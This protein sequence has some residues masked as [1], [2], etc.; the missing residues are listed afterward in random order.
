MSEVS[1]TP[2]NSGSFQGY[3]LYTAQQVAQWPCVSW[4]VD[5]IIQKNSSAV[6]Y[7]ESRAGKSFLAL[8]LAYKLAAGDTWFGYKVQPC[9]VIFFAAES[10]SGLPGRISAI[11]AHQ[12]EEAPE[13]LLFMREHIELSDSVRI[14][15]LI[16]TVNGF[17]VIF[18]DTLNAAAS[19]TNEN[20]VKEMGKILNGIRR[21]IDETGCTVI[22]V[23]HC[24]W[25]DHERLRGHSSFSAAMDTRIHVTRE[26]GHPTWKV[27]GQREGAETEA[28]RYALRQIILPSGTSCIVDPLNTLPAAKLAAQPRTVN[29]KIVYQNALS[30]LSK[31]KSLPLHI[32][33]L[34]SESAKEIDADS[35]HQRQRAVEA[36][37]G[38][39]KAGFIQVDTTGL[40][41]V[42]N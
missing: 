40:V 11:K 39:R 4:L 8:D 21:I 6:I 22:F 31:A 10:P 30:L 2:N 12:G 34:I 29:Q 17:D 25:S 5:G 38:L 37:D 36:V 19:E 27:K 35:R 14:Q 16:D 7:G 23:H 15:K 24:G 9:K 42:R 32:H 28:H 1:H 33:T 26:S 41:S 18:I 20:D 3:S 13:N